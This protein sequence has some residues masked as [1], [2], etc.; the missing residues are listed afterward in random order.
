MQEDGGMVASRIR[1]F[2][3]SCCWQTLFISSSFSLLKPSGIICMVGSLL[4]P[5]ALQIATLAN[6]IMLIY[7]QVQML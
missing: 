7:V 4:Y 1:F 6:R 3:R 5:L 2:V